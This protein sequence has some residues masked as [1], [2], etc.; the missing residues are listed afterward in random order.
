MSGSS[1][2]VNGSKADIIVIG[3]QLEGD[4]RDRC[5]GIE[6]PERLDRRDLHVGT[7]VV[8]SGAQSSDRVPYA[9]C[10]ITA[11]EAWQCFNSSRS[12]LGILVTNRADNGLPS[13]R[14]APHSDSS[15]CIC[16]NQLVLILEQCRQFFSELAVLKAANGQG[17]V[18]PHLCVS[19]LCHWLKGLGR[20]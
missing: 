17:H 10:I 7:I 3:S 12:N 5:I 6:R 2:R 20:L 13:E 15:E 9:L 16:L 8:H 19:I 11:D 4:T 1:Q 18:G 14:I